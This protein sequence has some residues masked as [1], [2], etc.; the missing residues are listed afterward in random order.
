MRKKLIV[1]GCSFV[2]HNFYSMSSPEMDT[3]FPKWAT[4]VA[5]RLDMDL[6]NL[7]YSGAGNNHVLS[8]LTD[9]IANTPKEEIGFVLAAWSQAQREDFEIYDPYSD[10]RSQ[11]G[12]GGW[13]KGKIDAAKLVSRRSNL[14]RKNKNFIWKNERLGRKGD[15]FYWVLDTLRKYILFERMCKSYDLPYKQ[16]QMI[17]PFNGY[18]NGLVK[19]DFEVFENRHN[20]EFVDR[21]EY[22]SILENEKKDKQKILE[23]I[24][25]YEKHLDLKNFIGWPIDHSIGGHTIEQKCLM[26]EKKRLNKP[27][28]IISQYDF[29]PNERGHQIIADYI[30]GHLV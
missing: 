6:I 15:L 2:D 5:D 28:L 20:P 19:T 29:H 16:F 11:A 3:S 23:L 25:E 8:T 27:E 1:S 12:Q 10:P 26:T 22:K 9:C 17:D 7:A 30:Y 18:L 24:L 13:S 4:I 14:D 21:Y